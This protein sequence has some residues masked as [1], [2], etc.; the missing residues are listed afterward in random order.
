MATDAEKIVSDFCKTWQRRNLEEI[1]AYFADDAVYHNMPM[2]PAR[3]TD[4]IKQTINTF[5]PGS[6]YIEFKILHSACNGNIVFNERLDM[7][8]MNG[9]HI[10]LPVAGVFE[11]KN[12]KITLWRDYFDMPSFTRQMS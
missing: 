8:E 7:F 6:T 2:D 10:E 1:M 11:V 12:G 5:L 4:A 9:K 3:G